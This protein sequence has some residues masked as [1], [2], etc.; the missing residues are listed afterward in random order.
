MN[1]LEIAGF[2]FGIAGVWLTI[3]EHWT[4]F[5]IGLV[6][7][8]ISLFLF[9]EQKLY[10]DSLQQGVY[11]FLLAYGWYQWRNVNNYSRPV[12]GYLTGKMIAI[13][14]GLFLLSAY[15]M[16]FLFGKYTDADVPFMDATA[17]TLSFIAQ[18]LIAKKKIENWLL[19]MIVNLMY[20]GIYTYKE[21]YFYAVLFAIYLVLAVI[22]YLKWKKI[23]IATGK[24]SANERFN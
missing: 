5:P 9:M 2:I 8:T 4:C 15:T 11:I 18:Y 20:I 21:L 23:L 1:N 19:W 13:L 16:G 24:F 10:S 3:K 7:V 6:N 14:S 17:T 22:G 12:V